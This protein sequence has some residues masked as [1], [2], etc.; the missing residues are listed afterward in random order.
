MSNERG[1]QALKPDTLFSYKRI[2]SEIFRILYNQFIYIQFSGGI[3][4]IY[5]IEKD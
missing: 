2:Y 5:Q 3:G 4:Q 1:S